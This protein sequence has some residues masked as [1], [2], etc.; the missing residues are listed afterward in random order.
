MRN[1]IEHMIVA[2]LK[3][4]RRDFPN[5][6]FSL[7]YKI[8]RNPHIFKYIQEKM[9]KEGNPGQ[10][11]LDFWRDKY[12]GLGEDADL[13]PATPTKKCIIIFSTPRSGS[14]LL[15]SLMASTK[16]LGRPLEYFNMGIYKPLFKD[17]FKVAGKKEYIEELKKKRTS[18]QRH[19]FYE[20]DVPSIFA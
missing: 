4:I 14:T 19:I 2:N 5:F 12:P 6:F 3:R 18:P 8:S 9:L 7:N 20:G 15:G 13:L 1:R 17:R 10:S 16:V 11:T